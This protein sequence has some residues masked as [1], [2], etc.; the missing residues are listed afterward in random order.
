MQPHAKRSYEFGPTADGLGRKLA[1]AGMQR[2]K[3]IPRAAGRTP[4]LA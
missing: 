2:V 3:R 1:G 4:P